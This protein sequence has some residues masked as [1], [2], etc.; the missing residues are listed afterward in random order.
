[1][2]TYKIFG[3]T[4][5]HT[6]HG[7]PMYSVVVVIDD[8]VDQRKLKELSIETTYSKLFTRFSIEPKDYWIHC[9][10]E[11]H[12][13]VSHTEVKAELENILH[14]IFEGDA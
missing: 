9:Y 5:S 12:P 7:I 14:D 10:G 6:K 3:P 13:L 11:V 8:H 4:Q 2:D 1:M